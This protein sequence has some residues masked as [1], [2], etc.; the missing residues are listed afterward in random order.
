MYEIAI[1]KIIDGNAA[2]IKTIGIL[3]LT[4]FCIYVMSFIVVSVFL[5]LL[6]NKEIFSTDKHSVF[7]TQVIEIL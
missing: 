3:V 5:Y 1:S 4:F 7:I 2:I 6:K